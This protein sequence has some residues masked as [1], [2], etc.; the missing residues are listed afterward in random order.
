MRTLHDCW[1]LLETRPQS[2]SIV[3]IVFCFFLLMYVVS[4]I[5]D[6]FPRIF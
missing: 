2:S 4:L 6:L 1:V 5:V 3:I